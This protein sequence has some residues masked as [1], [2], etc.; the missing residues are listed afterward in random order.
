MAVSI[1]D[2]A[3]NAVKTWLATKLGNDVTVLNGWPDPDMPLPAK[4]I[5][6]YAGHWEDEHLQPEVDSATAVPNSVATKTFRWRM[7]ERTIPFQLD[8]WS[9]YEPVRSDIMARIDNALMA[10][11][12]TNEPVANGPLLS[13]ADGWTGKVDVFLFGGHKVDNS[14]ANQQSEYRA[15]YNG[16]ARVI[17]YVD[18]ISPC[19]NTI[20]FQQT[21]N[22]AAQP[23]VLLSTVS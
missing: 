9:T 16:E 5:S 22:G 18:V 17:L 15:T 1:Q 12:L 8:V 7:T 13:L 3:M 6:V 19:Q 21:I 2:A 11:S 14:Y 20:I 4:A 23:D 10:G